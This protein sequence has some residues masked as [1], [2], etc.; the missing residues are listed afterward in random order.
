M[1]TQTAAQESGVR[2]R[3]CFKEAGNA[4]VASDV[5]K[6]LTADQKYLPSKYFYDA[7]GS[8]L[9][10][11]ICRLP[12][13]YLTRMEMELLKR[14]AGR[15]MRGFRAGDLVELGSGANWKIR[16]LLDAMSRSDRAS[17]RYV[18]V[19][20]SEAAISASSDELTRLYPEL[21][22]VPLVAD[23]TR[24][25]DRIPR[26]RVR[27][28]FLF[29]STIG[30]LDEDDTRG[31]LTALSGCLRRGDRFFL[32][33]D[34]IKPVVILE[35]AYNDSQG[36]T[37][38]FNKNILLVLNKQLAGNFNQGD[39]DHVAFFNERKDQVEMHLRARRRLTVHFQAMDFSVSIDKGETILTEI[40]RKFRRTGVESAAR[41]A[42]LRVSEWYSDASEWFSIAEIVPA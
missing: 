19:D 10:E 38:Q 1:N 13:Y 17:A 8:K 6:G 42:G 26:H 21:K 30:N 28:I 2:L 16:V 15:F 20:V 36:I 37:A 5:L 11:V 34:M 40:C 9:F 25:L 32:G 22:I 4:H 7:R 27:M 14:F 12:E 39:F 23:F 35:A 24:D 31:F 29:G 33:L 18:P 41:G 3:R